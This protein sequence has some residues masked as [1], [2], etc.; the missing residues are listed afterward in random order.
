MDRLYDIKYDEEF[1]NDIMQH[2]YYRSDV[3]IF[4]KEGEG[5]LLSKKH[6]FDFFTY[7]NSLSLSKWK[8][9]TTL[10]KFNLVLEVKGDFELFVFGHYELPTGRI[11]KEY[12]CKK[13]IIKEE[14]EQIIIN[15]PDVAKSTVVGFSVYTHKNTNIYDAYWATNTSRSIM[16]P[17]KIALSTT[18]YKKENYVIKNM[19]LLKNN[20]FN[21]QNYSDYFHWFIVDN[22]QTLPESKF[23]DEHITL[24]KNPN[25]GG[26]GG[27]ARGMM[28]TIKSSG[29]SHILLMDDDVEMTIEGFKRLWLLLA[30]MKDEYKGNFVS[31]AMLKMEEPNIQHEDIG[32]FDID[33][34][35]HPAKPSFDLNLWDSIVK[36]ESYMYSDGK[37]YYSGW[38]FCCIP[39]QYVRKDNLPLPIF[40]RGDDVEYSLRNR[41]GFISMNGICIWHDGFEGKFS[42]AMEF[43][44]VERNEL[45]ISAIHDDLNDVNVLG[46]IEQFFWEEIYKFNYKG[47]SLLL[48]A[49]EDYLKGPEYVFSL[50][51]GLVMSQK[52]LLDNKTIPMTNEVFSILPTDNSIYKWEPIKGRI[53]KF[54]YDY[55]CNGQMRIPEFLF[56]KLK[57]AVIPYGWGYFQSKMCFAREI[58]AVDLRSKKYVI[59]KKNRKEF[60]RLKR[61]YRNLISRYENDNNRISNAYKE[62]F[63]D[64]VSFENWEKRTVIE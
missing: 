2:M 3:M 62:A 19:T 37:H 17:I 15:I 46:R 39:I 57:N 11:A 41:P 27:F 4:D 35:H 55:T 38:W 22:G 1:G 58:V 16:N 6:N 31:G 40:V 44:Q 56:G 20:I 64:A 63:G 52:K 54:I 10:S 43:Y 53:R 50:D 7:F 59:Y 24:V 48:D 9:Y 34:R 33:G 28:E 51:G 49:I 25:V 29:F 47:A 26:A 36:N 21:N 42:A 8:M 61:R 5:H 13:R 23:V 12:F 60:C 32:V 30:Y 14:R 18:T 45:I